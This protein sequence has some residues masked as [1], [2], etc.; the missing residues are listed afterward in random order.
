MSDSG[1]DISRPRLS[2]PDVTA[3]DTPGPA[4]SGPGLNAAAPRRPAPQPPL[5]SVTRE[6]RL[7]PAR[8]AFWH[9]V[10]VEMLTTLS[11]MSTETG[12]TGDGRMAVITH[13]GQRIPISR[14]HPLMACSVPSGPRSLST[15]L[16]C[17]VFQITTPGGEVYTLPVHEIAS[18]HTLTPELVE[19]LAEARRQAGDGAGG[20]TGTD[21]P[22][23]FAAFTS[24]ARAERDAEEEAGGGPLDPPLPPAV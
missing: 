5:A 14:V 21:E 3:G 1:P 4:I 16:Q 19:A 6:D 24:L 10:I 20:A 7:G 11:A 9:Q 17:S 13:Q 2:G 12:A 22:F 18:I 23:G 15:I 8:R